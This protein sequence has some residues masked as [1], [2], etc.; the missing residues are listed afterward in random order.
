MAT[1]AKYRVG[2]VVLHGMCILRGGDWRMHLAGMLR[3]F[4]PC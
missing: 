1:M 2:R 3:E 4:G